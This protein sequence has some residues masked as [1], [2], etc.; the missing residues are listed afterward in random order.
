MSDTKATPKK[1]AFYLCVPK[2]SINYIHSDAIYYT[3]VCG[4]F[5]PSS[6]YA[7]CFQYDNLINQMLPKDLST[8]IV[9]NYFFMHNFSKLKFS[10]LFYIFIFIY[11]LLGSLPLSTV[12]I[13]PLALSVFYLTANITSLE[14]RQHDC[15]STRRL[16]W[17]KVHLRN[18]PSDISNITDA[19]P[20]L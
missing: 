17:R 2:N 14:L 1:L 16:N 6:R 12:I 19:H 18:T 8:E 5:I 20:N 13:S 15:V 10:T 3:L 4:Y 7:R 9:G 11:L